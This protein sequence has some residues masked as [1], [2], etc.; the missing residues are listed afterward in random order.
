MFRIP[1]FTLVNIVTGHEVI[2][3]LLMYEFTVESVRDELRRLLTDKKYVADMR[4][5]YADLQQILG[6]SRAAE[7]AA[8]MIAG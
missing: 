2:R 4:S 5:G 7:T 3:E 6:T 8:A 1:H